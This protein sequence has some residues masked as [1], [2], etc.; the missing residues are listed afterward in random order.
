MLNDRD[1]RKILIK[2]YKLT[3]AEERLFFIIREIYFFWGETRACYA[4]NETLISETNMSSGTVGRAL[5]VLESKKLIK[6]AY[7]KT[8]GFLSKRN[9]YPLED[10]LLKADAQS[11][12]DEREQLMSNKN[13][14]YADH[15]ADQYDH[16]TLIKM[17][18]HADQN[19]HINNHSLNNH[20][21]NNINNINDIQNDNGTYVNSRI[22]GA[23]APVKTSFDVSISKPAFENDP[24]EKW[25]QIAKKFNL[26]FVNIFS[27][28]RI[29]KLKARIKTAGS[30]SAFWETVEKSLSG[31]AFLRG[32][33]TDWRASLD[34]FLQESSFLKA[35]E[36]VYRRQDKPKE[37]SIQEQNKLVLDEYKR[38][39]GIM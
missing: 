37:L 24:K 8:K 38:A 3:P 15:Y 9:I 35:S 36:D 26:P 2:T 19:D 4:S 27:K 39:H 31:S 34:F 22:E 25:N 23:K 5:K 18:N 21:L 30:E 14:V 20:S 17:K 11:V 7:E 32:E 10:E 28:T 13:E 12:I 6:L 33:I 29:Q 16:R 1:V